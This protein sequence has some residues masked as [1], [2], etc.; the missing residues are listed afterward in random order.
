[1][2]ESD[3]KL[4]L[5]GATMIES[6][7]F[8]LSEDDSDF[9]KN[10][11]M[12]YEGSFVFHPYLGIGLNKYTGMLND[13]QTRQKMRNEIQTKLR[14]YD[15]VAKVLVLPVDDSSI[16]C[17]IEIVSLIGTSG[18]KFTFNFQNGGLNYVSETQNNEEVVNAREPLNVY[19]RRR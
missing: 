3:I 7:D 9:V 14:D 11:L 4:T 5:A 13:S 6:G 2:Y 15:I 8:I 19:M 10:M 1:M 16:I 12:V 18:V 17:N